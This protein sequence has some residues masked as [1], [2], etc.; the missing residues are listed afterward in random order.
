MFPY[1]IYL[2]I[3]KYVPYKTLY[4]SVR[5]VNHQLSNIACEVIEKYDLGIILFFIAYERPLPQCD[6]PSFIKVERL[7]IDGQ[8][9][10]E[11]ITFLH[12]IKKVISACKIDFE[13]LDSFSS[14]VQRS[15]INLNTFFDSLPTRCVRIWI[16]QIHFLDSNYFFFSSY[17][18][19]CFRLNIQEFSVG[20]DYDAVLT[21][22]FG[23][24]KIRREL[25]LMEYSESSVKKL[26]NYISKEATED[27][28]VEN[29]L[30]VNRFNEFFVVFYTSNLEWK[31]R[32]MN[33]NL[34][35]N[36]TGDD[37]DDSRFTIINIE[38]ENN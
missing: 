24:P 21:W 37:I 19:N 9:K 35:N 2:H 16:D 33:E 31:E 25:N 36:N 11:L 1:E 15:K 29:K 38:M 5:L 18:R 13:E 3:L 22:L 34:I 28:I 8:I 32:I 10:P 14:E 7:H 17:V 23:E 26:F 12:R 27:F 6:P 20:S 4:R 30:R